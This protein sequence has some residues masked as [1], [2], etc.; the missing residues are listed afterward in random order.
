MLKNNKETT[1]KCLIL[2]EKKV[3]LLESRVKQVEAQLIALKEV[4]KK[5]K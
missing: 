3:A 5:L 2:T 1:S 4:A